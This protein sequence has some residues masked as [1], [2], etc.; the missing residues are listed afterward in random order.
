MEKYFTHS[1][2]IV[3]S[4]YIGEGTK[5]W[6]F[7]HICK[8]AKI[9]KNCVIAEGVYI[10]PNVIIGDN[11]RIQNRS[12]IYAGVEIGN[13]VFIGPGVVTTNDI[14]PRLPG[15]DWTSRFRKTLIKDGA[16]LCA[17]TTIVCGITIGEKSMVG[18]GSVITKN[19]E[20]GYLYFGN[21]AKKIRKIF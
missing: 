12:L 1:T 19:T 4:E 18:A 11:C 14:F 8:D 15:A 13:D 6:A 5:I 16:S 21:P 10:G 3:E 17:N 2:A 9:G 20:D 7:C